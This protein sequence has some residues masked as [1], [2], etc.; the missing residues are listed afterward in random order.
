MASS[1]T[2]RDITGR[3]TT[4]GAA[5]E[6][7]D[8][9]L[10]G[11]AAASNVAIPSGTLVVSDWIVTAE[12]AARFRLQRSDDSGSSWYDVALLRV[13]SDGTVGLEL[14]I[15]IAYEGSADTLLRVRVETPGGAAA[16]TTT[17]R[18]YL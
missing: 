8:L 12:A 5:E 14:K 10:D 13:P 1:K 3:A 16:V 17:I 6:T 4:A 2:T 7:L 11:A 18:S 9:E 15:T